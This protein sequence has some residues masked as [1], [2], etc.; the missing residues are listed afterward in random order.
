[1][2]E[3]REFEEVKTY[4][5]LVKRIRDELEKKL[6]EKASEFCKSLS[7]I[8]DSIQGRVV[9]DRWRFD[10]IAAADAGSSTITLGDTMIA[11]L[12]A[13][14]V[15]LDGLG[16]ER[17]LANPL[18][19]E[20]KLDEDEEEFMATVDNMRETMLMRIAE[21]TVD[22]VDLLIIDG[23]LIPI[24]RFKGEYLEA[25][26]R[27]VKRCE[28]KNVALAGFV[29]RPQQRFISK[30]LD[31]GSKFRDSTILSA[32]LSAGECYPWP[33]KDH[34]ESRVKLTFR[35]TYLKTI[36]DRR[37]LPFRI[38]FPSYVSDEM[39]E[40]I[41]SYFLSTCD[42]NRGV[43]AMVMM[44]DEEVKLSKR[45]IRDLYAEVLESL[46]SRF[47]E[48]SWGSIMFRWGEFYV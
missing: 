34:Y 4:P 5:E 38:D 36:S 42:P 2:E 24:P 21:K 48:R 11:I 35:Y 41:L 27:L 43:P 25:V 20:Q 10:K 7:K 1:M 9:G 44:A 6:S 31:F 29:K 12:A 33:P 8:M 37:I 16:F 14:Y 28:K 46:I 39:A 22:D 17:G 18:I 15:R 40:T 23:P 3:L 30:E 13:L 19:L 45:L 47:P 26:R 32:V